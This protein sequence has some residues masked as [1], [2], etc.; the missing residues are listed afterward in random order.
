MSLIACATTIP[1]R[2][3]KL[4]TMDTSG[5]K[6]LAV[7]PFE[8]SDTS[9]LQKQV[10]QLLTSTVNEIIVGTNHFTPVAASEVSR[11]ERAGQSYAAMVDALFTGTLIAVSVTNSS[12]TEKYTDY[13]GEEPVDRTRTMYD[14][15]VKLDF[16]Y[17]LVRA[18]DGSIISQVN[19]SGIASDHKE[20]S[21]E[22]ST[23]FDLAQV[24]VE[25][26]LRLL[27]RDVAPWRA[28]E[29]RTLAKET[30]KDKEVKRRMKEA[31]AQVKLGSHKIA[32]KLYLQIY[33][34]TGSFAAAY[35]AAILTEVLGNLP[36]AIV[37]M[38]QLED[39][40]GNL[41][42]GTELARME[43]TLADS[44]TLEEQYFSSDTLV[45]RAIKQAVA[46]IIAKL[47]WE[48]RISILNISTLE[49]QLMEYIIGEM[50]TALV[51]T[52]TIVERQNLQLLEAEKQFQA[53]G[54]VSD[55][56][57]VSIGQMLGVNTL[58]TCTITGSSNLRRLRIRAISVE[59]GTIVYED[60][61]EI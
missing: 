14:R 41:K 42:A 7:M 18:W 54:E 1:V 24:I 59:T 39:E 28:T 53:S 2:V 10:A 23:P 32:L 58:I 45:D 49:P 26:T 27:N 4:P 20:K 16:T 60:S 51:N 61:L 52:V 31:D 55:T 40:T 25:R 56:S 29:R 30:S 44:R 17:R 11:L 6:R 21:A 43:Q 46:N 9:D 35:N 36:G 34:D 47:P 37:L 22:L 48:S 5:I 50:T 57:A 38:Q 3:T 12:H 33:E 8:T 15:E 19:K 13:S